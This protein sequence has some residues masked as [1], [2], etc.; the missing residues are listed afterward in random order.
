MRSVAV[1]VVVALIAAA[2][3]SAQE[4]P[5]PT[6]PSE[7]TTWQGEFLEVHYL[8]ENSKPQIAYDRPEEDLARRWTFENGLR[9]S[10]GRMIPPH[11]ILSYRKLDPC[12]WWSK[13]HAKEAPAR[14][15]R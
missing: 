10:D 2:A 5:L 12:L 15:R 14:K 7:C 4:G 9:L 11:R 13:V 6:P 8:D 3:V 1:G